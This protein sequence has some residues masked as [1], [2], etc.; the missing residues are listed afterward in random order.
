M[1]CKLEK[2]GLTS[3]VYTDDYSIPDLM[4]NLINRVK[5]MEGTVQDIPTI[6]TNV[7]K[8][9]VD[10]GELAGLVSEQI[11]EHKLNCQ[12]SYTDLKSSVLE[13]N[14]L[15]LVLSRGT[16]TDGGS[17]V[18]FVTK[19]SSDLYFLMDTVGEY[20][21]YYIPINNIYNIRLISP[22]ST[23]LETL[24]N[25]HPIGSKF[26]FPKGTYVFNN[27]NV[28]T[29]LQE[30][31]FYGDGTGTYA[32]VGSSNITTNSNGA[33]FLNINA[34]AYN[35]Y[36]KDLYFYGDKIA[37]GINFAETQPTNPTFSRADDIYFNNCVFGS[38]ART[39]V[40]INTA[41]GYVYFKN[42]SF[43]GGDSTQEAYGVRVGESYSNTSGALPNYVYFIESDFS[44]TAGS[45]NGGI[46]LYNGSQFFA[47]NC[48]FALLTSPAILLAASS[49][50]R[51]S[52]A[53]VYIRNNM[54]FNLKS[55]GI[56]YN[57]NQLILNSNIIENTFV[58]NTIALDIT[59]SNINT[60]NLINNTFRNFSNPITSLL[61]INNTII[62]TN[63][64]GNCN[65]TGVYL[66][67]NNLYRLRADSRIFPQPN[68]EHNVPNGNTTF[69]LGGTS[70]ASANR[71]YYFNMLNA[72][73]PGNN[74]TSTKSYNPVTNELTI[75]LNNNSQNQ[76]RIEYVL[77]TNWR[78]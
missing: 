17:G 52:I 5:N 71:Q 24:I 30:C 11:L 55:S 18:V 37:N 23:Q 56:K 63:L 54:F 35:L 61:T 10:T 40:Q 53:D 28:N 14:S 68:C 39:G 20:Y 66:T 59:G 49:S 15:N 70:L 27:I 67:E 42:C 32:G 69:V 19:Q 76:Y 46:A 75:V 9:M 78:T 4:Y 57:S 16:I 50:S 6:L 43:L 21:L 31:T 74:V 29:R 62:S 34:G 41:C 33:F 64:T 22:T 13:D 65:L 8:T 1:G 60:F 44:Q 58:L 2:N 3:F 51:A 48:D 12:L 25:A 26:Y 72:V 7:I 73:N 38:Y 77:D 47:Q 36:F 45:N